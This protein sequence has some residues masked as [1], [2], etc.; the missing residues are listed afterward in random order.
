M[1]SYNYTKTRDFNNHLSHSLP[2]GRN[3]VFG[4]KDKDISKCFVRGERSR[5]WDLDGNEY[6]DL[7]CKFGAVVLGHK[8]PDFQE[9]LK[10]AIA[11]S[12]SGDVSDIDLETCEILSKHIPSFEK[13]RFGLSG[14]ETIQNAIRLARAYTNKKWILR[15]TGHFHGSADGIMGGNINTKVA[16]PFPE[17]NETNQVFGTLGRVY[18]A[19]L[20]TLLIPWNDKAKLLKVIK[21]KHMDIA[22]IIFEP[23]NIN[24][25]GLTADKDYLLLLRDLCTCYGVLLIFD[26]VITGVRLGMGGVQKEIGVL[27]DLSIFAKGIGNGIP[28]SLLCGKREIMDMYLS[29][30]VVY[31]GTFY[32]YMLGMAAIKAT[33][34][35]LEENATELY[36]TKKKISEEIYKMLVINANNA[37][38]QLVI[39]GP[40]GCASFMINEKQIHSYDELTNDVILKNNIVKE[41]LAAH[42]ILICPTSRMYSGFCLDES[43]LDFLEKRLGK[44]MRDAAILLKRLAVP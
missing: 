20:Q 27:P 24:S 43:D 5:L 26:E 8:H 42:G 37:G 32:G 44:A 7:Y 14:S 25:G 31:G 10:A 1:N 18:G 41:C 38:I 35:I 36:E 3:S 39:Q 34:S 11:N 15:F 30:Q 9:H 12:T 13:V 21:S 33:Y 6:L 40:C 23:I 19:E 22:A 4:L 17:F 16:T 2:A 28:V 29:S